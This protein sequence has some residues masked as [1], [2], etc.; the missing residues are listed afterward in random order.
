MSGIY[1]VVWDERNKD[2]SQVLRTT[3][4]GYPHVTVAYTG[5]ELS[6]PCLQ[7]LAAS[8]ISEWVLKT[9]TLTSAVVNSFEDTPGHVR[10]DVLL[11][12]NKS[13][14]IEHTRQTFLRA[15]YPNHERFS[16][17]KPHVTYGIYESKEDAKMIAELL[18][19]TRLPYE[20]VVTGVTID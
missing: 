17:I 19:A 16:M 2:K 11:L 18:N 14:E 12:T 10:H 3:K 5:K 1:L 9:L 6:L 20:V 15:N 8:M 4:G 13:E 7:L